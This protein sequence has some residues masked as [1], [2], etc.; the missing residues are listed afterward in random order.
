MSYAI[1]APLSFPSGYFCI[2]EVTVSC[3]YNNLCN[4]Y[5]NL[6]SPEDDILKNPIFDETDFT[7]ITQEIIFVLEKRISN[8]DVFSSF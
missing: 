4:E 2:Y 1:G 7:A 8:L 3:C 5:Q 6:C